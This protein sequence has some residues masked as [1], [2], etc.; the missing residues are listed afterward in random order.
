MRLKPKIKPF[1]RSVFCGL[2]NLCS[3]LICW[4]CMIVG[5]WIGLVYVLVFHSDSDSESEPA[6]GGVVCEITD[7]L[8]RN[9]LNY[10]VAWESDGLNL[11]YRKT[12]STTSHN[13]GVPTGT[14]NKR[15]GLPHT[16]EK[17]LTG[18]LPNI[19]AGFLMRGHLS[20]FINGMDWH[21]IICTVVV[22]LA[23]L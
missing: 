13:P 10:T 6:S 11:Q 4:S 23:P 1:M 17:C 21:S 19:G 3:P 5:L 8:I 15:L 18:G 16:T 2:H 9:N 22:E 20:L 12:I 14:G 7:C